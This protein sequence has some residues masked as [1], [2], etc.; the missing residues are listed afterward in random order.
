MGLGLTA[1]T[2]I[3]SP[4]GPIVFGVL[5]SLG[6]S[7]ILS[8]RFTRV[9][10]KGRPIPAP[11]I[12]LLAAVALVTGFWLRTTHFASPWCWIFMWLGLRPEPI[13]TMGDYYPLLP[14]IA[15][16]WL[17][18]LAARAW[19][20][21]IPPAQRALPE[22]TSTALPTR[23]LAWIGRHALMIYVLHQPYCSASAYFIH[24]LRH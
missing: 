17:G 8:R 13:P 20:A 12:L 1:A 22:P 9:P 16:L 10:S 11:V 24:T 21:R 23:S 4:G 18:I 2:F 19:A 14:D 15:Y 5:H 6:L 7:K 3:Y